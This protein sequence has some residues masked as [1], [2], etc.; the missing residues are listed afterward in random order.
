M[1]TSPD[2]LWM[3]SQTSANVHQMAGRP[4]L[5]VSGNRAGATAAAGLS[6]FASA[7]C[8]DV[9]TGQGRLEPSIR[10]EEIELVRFGWRRE[11]QAS[12]IVNCPAMT[13]YEMYR[14][15][16]ER[17]LREPTPRS[18]PVKLA[19]PTDLESSGFAAQ[20]PDNPRSVAIT[21]VH[22]RRLD[23]SDGDFCAGID[24]TV[25]RYAIVVK[26]RFALLASW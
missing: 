10:R 3:R 18:C 19:E 4:S 13:N 23:G 16:S 20:C 15:S 24:R 2:R 5:A 6:S 1:D 21:A 12:P 17:D 26:P 9:C 22:P 7:N 11:P 14:P 8:S 25:G